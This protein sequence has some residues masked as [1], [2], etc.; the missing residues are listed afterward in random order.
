M[1]YFGKSLSTLRRRNWKFALGGSGGSPETLVQGSIS[2]CGGWVK[3]KSKNCDMKQVD[4][5]ELQN[6][7][8]WMHALSKNVSWYYNEVKALFSEKNERSELLTDREDM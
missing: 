7:A 3:K 2:I 1:F 6:K 8:Y 5:G 4:L